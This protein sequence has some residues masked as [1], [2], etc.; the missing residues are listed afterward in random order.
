ML[1]PQKPLISGAKCSFDEHPLP[2]V[3]LV[4]CDRPLVR[5]VAVTYW[6]VSIPW[7]YRELTVGV[8]R[9]DRGRTVSWLWAYREL[10]V[11][12]LW[13]YRGRTHSAN[14]TIT[15][16]LGTLTAACSCKQPPIPR[17]ATSSGQLH[18]KTRTKTCP[19]CGHCCLLWWPPQSVN[20]YQR[21]IQ[22]AVHRSYTPR[23]K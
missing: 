20:I 4:T 8:P 17:H 23:Q 6:Q 14:P 1:I 7:A 3:G 21:F 9:A 13:A 10:T 19:N 12:V 18:L 22:T 11:G 16:Q 15:L 5:S 2:L